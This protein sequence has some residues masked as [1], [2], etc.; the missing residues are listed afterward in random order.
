MKLGSWKK[1]N[2]KI[3]KRFAFVPMPMTNGDWLW[4]ETYW[5]V[6]EWSCGFDYDWFCRLRTTNQEEAASFFNQ[7]AAGHG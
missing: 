5:S 2:W 7:K 1:P 6:S 4:L 3:R